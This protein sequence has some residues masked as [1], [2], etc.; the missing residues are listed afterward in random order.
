MGV[1]YSSLR[2][3]KMNYENSIQQKSKTLPENL[4]VSHEYLELEIQDHKITRLRCGEWIHSGWCWSL[5]ENDCDGEFMTFMTRV[6]F[7]NHV[8][9]DEFLT[10]LK[11]N[12]MSFKQISQQCIEDIKSNDYSLWP[13]TG[14]NVRWHFGDSS[15]NIDYDAESAYYVDESDTLTEKEF[16]IVWDNVGMN[17]PTITYE[18]FMAYEFGTDIKKAAVDAF[19]ESN[20]FDELLSQFDDIRETIDQDYSA[21]YDECFRTGMSTTI[22]LLRSGKLD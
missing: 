3:K 11:E 5:S 19:R 17:I 10:G 2:R 14:D 4:H 9:R 16:A 13:L 15:W 6:I 12:G 20:D 21:Y 8:A 7:A 22:S 18:G 1:R